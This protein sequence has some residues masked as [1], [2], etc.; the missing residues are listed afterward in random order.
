[1]TRRKTDEKEK[2]GI[3]GMRIEKTKY[4]GLKKKDLST[5]ERKIVLSKGFERVLLAIVL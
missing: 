4:V 1:M 3:S 2:M 5:V